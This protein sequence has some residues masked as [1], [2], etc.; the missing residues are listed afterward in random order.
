M[1]D[2]CKKETRNIRRYYSKNKNITF[3]YCWK[4]YRH[5]FKGR[6][7]FP[8]KADTFKKVSAMG[9]IY[10]LVSK[11]LNRPLSYINYL[12]KGDRRQIK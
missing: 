7:L 10:T 3:F 5:Q 1:C 9:D 8:A 4:C 11:D 6:L 12:S 2:L